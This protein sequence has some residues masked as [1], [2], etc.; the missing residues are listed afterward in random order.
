MRALEEA[1]QLVDGSRGVGFAVGE[2]PLPEALSSFDCKILA[3]DLGSG[4][5][6]SRTWANTGQHL[7]I[8]GSIPSRGICPEYKFKQNVEYDYVNMK[9]IPSTL[10]GYDFL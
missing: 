9:Q 8:Y 1:G 7:G 4:E 2:E 6:D 10:V 5:S 3:T